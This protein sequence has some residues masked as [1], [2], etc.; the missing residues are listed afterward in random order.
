LNNGMKVADVVD[1]YALSAPKNE[2]ETEI[3]RYSEDRLVA[4]SNTKGCGWYGSNGSVCKVQALK[5]TSVDGSVQYF[6]MSDEVNINTE[7]HTPEDIERLA[8]EEKRKALRKLTPQ[9]IEAL[10]LDALEDEL[11]QEI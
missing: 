2:R 11:K 6:L 10:G 4:E 3:L 8:R 1:I 5:L 9:D 7:K